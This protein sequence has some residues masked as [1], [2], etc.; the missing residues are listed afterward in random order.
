MNISSQLIVLREIRGNDP[1]Q[2]GAV[3]QWLLPYA[4]QIVVFWSAVGIIAA[5]VALYALYREI[6]AH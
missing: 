3:Q 5:C 4:H 6:R 1:V 2:L